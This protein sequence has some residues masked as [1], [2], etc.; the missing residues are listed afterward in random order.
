MKDSKQQSHCDFTACS[1]QY[2]IDSCDLKA[3]YAILNVLLA[4]FNKVKD[5]AV[6]SIKVFW[7][8]NKNS[9]SA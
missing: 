2:S 4:A 6:K 7:E 1:L 9:E 5:I 8:K 3:P